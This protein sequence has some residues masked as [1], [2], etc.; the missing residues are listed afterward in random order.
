MKGKRSVVGGDGDRHSVQMKVRSHT[1]THTRAH[2][3]CGRPILAP[4]H[5]APLCRS[6]TVC[7]RLWPLGR[8]VG[9]EQTRLDAPAPVDGVDVQGKAPPPPPAEPFAEAAQAVA[10]DGGG[11]T[12]AELY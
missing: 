2:V 4:A 9:C 11:A 3:G 8:F 10:E 6:A 1:P 12:L 7:A 5:R